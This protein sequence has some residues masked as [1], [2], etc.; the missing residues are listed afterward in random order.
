[1]AKIDRYRQLLQTVLNEY[2]AFLSNTTGDEI[3]V[4]TIFDLVHDHY[5]LMQVGFQRGQRRYGCLFHADIKNDKIWIQHDSTDL[6]IGNEFLA[7]GVPKDDIVLGYYTPAM[8]KFSE[9]AVA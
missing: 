9:F 6:G 3:E 7:R 4:Q 2:A 8:R 1:M 5:Q